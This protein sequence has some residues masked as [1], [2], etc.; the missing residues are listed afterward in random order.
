MNNTTRPSIKDDEIIEKVAREIAPSL[1]EWISST[2]V[3]GSQ[4]TIEEIIPELIDMIDSTYNHDAYDMAKYLDDEYSWSPDSDLVERLDCVDYLLRKFENEHT[5]E[6]VKF[7]KIQ[8]QFKVGDLVSFNNK[9]GHID[10]IDFDLAKYR[11]KKLNDDSTC[12]YIVKYEEAELVNPTQGA[13]NG[14]ES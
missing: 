5:K 4:D 12:R 1:L 8:P 3:D 13:E 10:S 2:S 6:W 14:K 11:I 7:F 9:Q